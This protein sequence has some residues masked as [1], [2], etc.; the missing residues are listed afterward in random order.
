MNLFWKK[1]LG[2]LKHTERYEKPEGDFMLVAEKLSELRN[3]PLIT[4]FKKLHLELKLS[5]SSV[6]KLSKRK[7]DELKKNPDVA[8]YLKHTAKHHHADVFLTFKDDFY[9]KNIEDSY[10]KAGF[11]FENQKL[12]K[13]YSFQNEQQAYNQGN[14]VSVYQGICAIH[15]RKQN[16]K[17]LAWHPHQGF[18]EKD[19]FYTSDVIQTASSFRQQGGIFKAKIRCSGKIHHAWWLASE[20]QQPH[21][22][23]FHFNGQEIQ[24][25]FVNQNAG[26]GVTITGINPEEFYVYTLQWTNSAMI[27]YINNAEVLRVTTELPQ[28]ELFMVFNSFIPENQ[29]GAEGLL[30]IDWVRV[31][32]YNT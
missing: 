11:Y 18:V 23:I 26:D 25:G 15:T 2:I 17:S 5:S 1:F 22:N 13:H 19:F 8:F 9:R 3:S 31:Y 24:M 27:W 16:L 30:E 20:L 7:I 32:Q 6:R 29:T 12:F 10:W 4:E 21:I 14:N 28:Q